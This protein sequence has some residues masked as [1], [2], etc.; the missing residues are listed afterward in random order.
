MQYTFCSF[1][2][3]WNILPNFTPFPTFSWGHLRWW[4]ITY[5]SPLIIIACLFNYILFDAFS[6]S[7]FRIF[8]QMIHVPNRTLVRLWSVSRSKKLGD[9]NRLHMSTHR[10]SMGKN[11]ID[12]TRAEHKYQ[13]GYIPSKNNLKILHSRLQ[14]RRGVN[15][16]YIEVKVNVTFINKFDN[17]IASYPIS[18]HHLPVLLNISSMCWHHCSKFCRFTSPLAK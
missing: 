6:L 3:F 7:P 10:V 5:L 17:Y 1:A 13:L 8:F 4:H 9:K 16:G 15:L 14:R 11:L 2:P 18:H 12:L